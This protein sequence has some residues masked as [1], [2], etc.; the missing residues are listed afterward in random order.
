MIADGLF[1]VLSL[2][3]LAVPLLPAL[4]ELR[5]ARD[6]RPLGIIQGHNGD[7]R[8]FARAFRAVVR[9]RLQQR[10]HDTSDD[11]QILQKAHQTNAP[12]E[13]S[14][15]AKEQAIIALGPMVFP[16]A[17]TLAHEVYGRHDISTG[18]YN[19]FRAIL[20]EGDLTLHSHTTV[21]RWAHADCVS[22][23]PKTVLPG[24]VSARRR[25]VVDPSSCFAR[26]HAPLIQFGA[27]RVSPHPTSTEAT[28][29]HAPL[30]RRA[31]RQRRRIIGAPVTLPA[32]AVVTR[33]L[34][35]RGP[36]NIGANCRIEASIKAHGL[37]TVGNRTHISGSIVS[38]D[39][40]DVG[41]EVEVGGSVIA[42]GFVIIRQDSVIGTP[43][44]LS[45]ITAEH[46]QLKRGVRVH[47]S[48]WARQVCPPSSR[49]TRA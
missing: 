16:E 18:R 34:I 12:D 44:A 4:L 47:G 17:F 19:H 1:I 28:K 25:I 2:V 30:V 41:R 26:L 8:R 36:L 7:V 21:T 9:R 39:D 45:S 35:V 10:T 20:A 31:R 27:R 23:G 38:T 11:F 33:D 14:T 49:P 32:G 15:P 24:R 3:A 6:A 37:V 42:E 46:I 22:I 29:P 43:G 13:A 5:F 40:I 48:V